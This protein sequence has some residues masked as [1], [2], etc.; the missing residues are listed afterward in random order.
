MHTF[1]KQLKQTLKLSTSRYNIFFW[2]KMSC[3]CLSDELSTS[4][5]NYAPQLAILLLIGACTVHSF[6]FFART[7]VNKETQTEDDSDDESANKTL[8]LLHLSLTPPASPDKG[9]INSISFP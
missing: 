2:L 7:M 1:F 6:K 5:L 4:H 8:Q 3:E 9:Y